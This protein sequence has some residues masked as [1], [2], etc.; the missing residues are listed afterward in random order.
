MPMISQIINSKDYPVIIISIL[1]NSRIYSLIDEE[2]SKNKTTYDEK[3]LKSGIFKNKEFDIIP[4]SMINYAIKLTGIL[5]SPNGEW[6]LNKILQEGW[7]QLYAYIK[8]SNKIIYDK[9][10]KVKGYQSQGLDN[11][12][13]YIVILLCMIFEKKVYNETNEGKIFIQ[14]FDKWRMSIIG[15]SPDLNELYKINDEDCQKTLVQMNQENILENRLVAEKNKNMVFALYSLLESYNISLN[16]EIAEL[17]I[18]GKLEENDK[19]LLN[20][21]TVCSQ[22]SFNDILSSDIKKRDIADF[23]ITARFLQGLIKKYKILYKEYMKLYK[24]S[25]INEIDLNNKIEQQKKTNEKLISENQELKEE[26]RKM[27]EEQN[28]HEAQEIIKIKR[29]Y[30]S[31]I[32]EMADTIERYKEENEALKTVIE[33]LLQG[34]H[35]ANEEQ[36]IND[37]PKVTKGVIIGGSP[38]W[39]Q[40]MKSI[41][42]HYKFIEAHEL[43]YDTKVLENAERIYFNTAYCSHALF[44]K[45]INIVRKKKLDIF[46][47][48][49]N[50]VTAGIRIFAQNNNRFTDTSLVS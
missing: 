31:S 42:P 41:V 5:L 48:N 9:I 13:F 22:N 34:N 21:Y 26:L 16:D 27:K 1:K 4:E 3:A 30:E 38:Q 20:I 45:T 7:P 33:D 50:S 18:S 46:F 19:E 47:I 43:N 17:S 14:N 29:Q 36:I 2:Y 23:I 28:K 25:L 15:D 10:A 6:F 32:Q 39:Q 12:L 35:Y 24:I 40:N 37:I 11:Y 8:N 44:Y 49:N